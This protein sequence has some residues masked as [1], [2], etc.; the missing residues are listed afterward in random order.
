MSGNQ[1]RRKE[2]KKSGWNKRLIFSV[3]AILIVL[4]AVV[5]LTFVNFGDKFNLFAA[6][7]EIVSVNN[8]KIIRVPKGGDLQ[9]AINKAQGGDIIELQAG[10]TY[11]EAKLP[12]KNIKDFITIQSSAVAQLPTDKRVNPSN[13]NS[14][15]KIVTRGKGNAAVSTENGAHHFRFIGIEFTAE[16]ADYIY[17]LIYLNTDSPK[18]T[19]VPRF[20]EFDR[21]Y[22]HPHKTGITRRGIAAN[23]GD[24]IIKNSYL[25]G[26]AGNQEETQA[27]AGWSGTKNLKIINNYLEAG[28]ETVLLGGADPFSAELIPADIEI[29]GNY[30]YKPLEW[31][32]KVTIKNDFEIKNAKR[33]QFIGNVLENNQSA[34]AMWITVRNQDGK[35]PFSTIEDVTVKD[36]L[37]ISAGTG[38]NILGKDDGH[39]SQT[40]KR[41]T[42][43]NNLF[44]DITNKEVGYGGYF[45]Q[46][47]NGEDILIANNT[48]F[49]VGNPLMF[50]GEMPKNFLFRDNIVAHDSYG[51]QGHP[52]IK[53]ADGQRIFQN[54]LIFNSKK[55]NKSDSVFP[56]GNIWIE[57]YKN[58]GFINAAQ[59]DFRLAANSKF[60]A[61]G[62]NGVDIGSNL[63][64]ADY[65]KIMAK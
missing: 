50:H 25:Q 23:S 38:I 4:S 15:A 40:L 49:N 61:K 32:K 28:A 31:F 9:A 6:P 44:L 43:T 21:C 56:N 13:A 41:L 5:G 7:L 33:V 45:I 62:K 1:V 42:I 14:M 39:P 11:Y 35:A 59:K 12:N 29:R 48:S 16:N 55:I 51:V 24:T 37:I 34:G 18:V 53:S 20:F 10:A 27:I 30:F 60:K 63:N 3:S 58:I 2:V 65:Q 47:S 8:Q 26:F 52:N 22:F 17:N 64:I 36:N 46:V 19:D 57:D 54:N